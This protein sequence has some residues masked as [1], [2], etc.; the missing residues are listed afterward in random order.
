MGYPSRQLG[1]E[2]DRSHLRDGIEM[3]SGR[4]KG[5]SRSGE[6]S[7]F[8]SQFQKSLLCDESRAHT[9]SRCYRT[10]VARVKRIFLGIE[11]RISRGI[12]DQT[13][14]ATF[15]AGILDRNSTSDELASKYYA[16]I[17]RLSRN[18][19][20]SVTEGCLRK[21]ASPRPLPRSAS[22]AIVA[23]LLLRNISLAS[24]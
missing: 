5:T 16:A 6:A 23:G 9:H 21:E 7:F 11:N 3:G 13:R 22:C 24:S 14:L 4:P 2:W 20:L 18:A 1:F 10:F 12:P 8:A 17:K 19:K 15:L